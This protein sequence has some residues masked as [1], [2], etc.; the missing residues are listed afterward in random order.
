MICHSFTHCATEGEERVGGGINT[1][2]VGCLG[3]C[4]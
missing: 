4:R 3:V 1:L 2:V